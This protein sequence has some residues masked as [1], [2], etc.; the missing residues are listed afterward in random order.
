MPTIVADVGKSRRVARRWKRILVVVLGL[1]VALSAFTYVSFRRNM[2]LAS[3]RVDSGNSLV[4]TAFRALGLLAIRVAATERCA[5]AYSG[6]EVN[7]TKS[8]PGRG[9]ESGK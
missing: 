6:I 9:L 5:G 3:A 2:K 7:P 8:R 1:I 4:S